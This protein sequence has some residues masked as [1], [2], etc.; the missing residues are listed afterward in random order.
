MNSLS[1]EDS[2]NMCF[3]EKTH[4][5]NISTMRPQICISTNSSD[6]QVFF[7]FFDYYFLINLSLFKD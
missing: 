7:T 3:E 6:G 4:F 5:E 1:F 2:M